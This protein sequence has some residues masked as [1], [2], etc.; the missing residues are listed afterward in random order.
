MDVGDRYS[1]LAI[2]KVQDRQFQRHCYSHFHLL[3][4]PFA[5]QIMHLKHLL[6]HRYLSFH[7]F[8]GLAN[9][10]FQRY[11]LQ[12]LRQSQGQS[13]DR[14]YWIQIQACL[15][16]RIQDC[17]FLQIDSTLLRLNKNQA[18]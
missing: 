10:N 3:F 14:I 12:H 17:Y 4:H 1:L 15:Q 9:P 2:V 13:Q 7:C 6:N 16:K 8:Q 18:R 11:G 5:L